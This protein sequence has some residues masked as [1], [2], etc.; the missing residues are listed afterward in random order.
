MSLNVTKKF[1]LK[2]DS[3]K[4]ELFIQLSASNLSEAEVNEFNKAY[5]AITS[6]INASEYILFIDCSGAGVVTQAMVQSLEAT[7]VV[8]KKTGFKKIIVDVGSSAV[9]GMQ[10][11]RVGLSAGLDNLEVIKK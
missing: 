8:Y 11:K 3:A 7:F 6:A 1:E 10:V 9:L 5:M 2:T 4:K